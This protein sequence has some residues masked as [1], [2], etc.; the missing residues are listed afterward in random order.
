M[1]LLYYSIPTLKEANYEAPT[2]KWQKE[3]IGTM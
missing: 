2:F 1:D 3:N